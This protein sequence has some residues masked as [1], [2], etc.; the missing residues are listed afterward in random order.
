MITVKNKQDLQINEE[1]IENTDVRVM[2]L[3]CS[4]LPWHLPSRSKHQ[5]ALTNS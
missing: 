1:L 4:L 5:L 2:N 3:N